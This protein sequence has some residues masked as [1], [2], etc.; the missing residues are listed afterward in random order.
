MFEEDAISAI[1][2]LMEVPSRS[3]VY[4]LGCFGRYITLY[5]Q[6]V[7]ALNLAYALNRRGKL[8]I[9]TRVCV[10]GAGIAGLTFAVGA[11]G[12]RTIQVMKCVPGDGT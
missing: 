6:Q 1:L 4:V 3:G 5:S 9:G 11:G 7:R 2:D 8:K 10:V 12:G